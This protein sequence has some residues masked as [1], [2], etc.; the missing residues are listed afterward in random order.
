MKRAGRRLF[1]GAL[2][3]VWVFLPL[4]PVIA[5]LATWTLGLR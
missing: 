3:G 4:M 1:G 2:M 5:A